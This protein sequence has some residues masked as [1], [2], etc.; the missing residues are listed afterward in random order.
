LHI[1]K[2]AIIHNE[3]VFYLN[4]DK[5]SDLTKKCAEIRYLIADEIGTLGV[6]HIGGSLSAVEA[7]VVLY[8][9]RMNIDPSNPQMEGRDRFVMSKGH[10]GPAL[11]AVLADK[12]YFP[13]ELLY[14]LNIPGTTLP[15][16][17]DMNLTK[18]VDMTAGSLGQ[19]FSCAVGIAYGS[20][21]SKDD[22]YT[23]VMIGDGETGEGQI[24]EAAM[25]AAQKS[26]DNLIA[27]T[28]YNKLQL[29][30]WTCDI[31]ELEPLG[32]K[33]RSFG[34]NVIEIDGHNVDAIDAAIT[35]AKLNKGKPSMIILHTIKGKGISFVEDSAPDNHSMTITK[36]QHNLALKELRGEFGQC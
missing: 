24:W 27:F 32:A 22:A 11:Y 16:H 20:K 9:K 23:Y 18:G 17:T 33:W 12:G 25:C 36:E 28:D 31:N 5:G 21:L 34:W 10:A 3:R 4:Y 26:L 14:T 15:S 13:K 8:Y 2:D 7:L 19:G 30:G 29:D 6:G 1:Y 35:L